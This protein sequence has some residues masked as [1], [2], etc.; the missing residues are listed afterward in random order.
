M[1][2]SDYGEFNA[3]ATPLRYGSVGNDD[4]GEVVYPQDGE[5]FPVLAIK[6]GGAEAVR[7]GREST[8]LTYKLF[9]DLPL[10]T[11]A[12]GETLSEENYLSLEGE[13]ARLNVTSVRPFAEDGPAIIECEGAD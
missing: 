12:N 3:T 2:V 6:G 4:L 8:T 7:R 13:S 11:R 1:P 5:A 9:A 10:P